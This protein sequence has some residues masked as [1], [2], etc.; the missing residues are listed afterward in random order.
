[1]SAVEK[2]LSSPPISCESTP[3]TA[4]PRKR[5]RR[6]AKNKVGYT[7][8]ENA[9][10]ALFTKGDWIIDGPY[11][12]VPPYYYVLLLFL[13]ANDRRIIPGP[14]SAGTISRC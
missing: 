9:N 8:P 7:K 14:N 2:H 12:R 13:R 10:A 5:R 3:P 4:P 6:A 1:M 11:R